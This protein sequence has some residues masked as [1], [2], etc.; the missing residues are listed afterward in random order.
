MNSG[1]DHFVYEFGP[2]RRE[3]GKHRLVR[4]DR[5]IPLTGKAFS[6]LCVA[7]KR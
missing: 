2:F 7:T 5:P 4:D 6:T 3:V 1:R